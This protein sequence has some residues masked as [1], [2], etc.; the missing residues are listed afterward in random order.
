MLAGV[1]ERGH[2]AVLA[3]ARI[4]IVIASSSRY[5]KVGRAE[6]IVKKVKFFLAS[7][8]KTWAFQ[9]A[10]DLYHKVSL[11]ALYMNER[12][13]FFTPGGVITPYSL[14]QAMLER[15]QGKPKFFTFGEYIVPS[16][17]QIYNQI[18][19]MA[20]FSKQILFKVV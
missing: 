2:A 20:E 1:S 10:F 14:E 8:L 12:P 3:N 7:A 6:F 4:K 5:E 18:L 19:K 16:D 17:K 15:A 9:D 11:M 13:I